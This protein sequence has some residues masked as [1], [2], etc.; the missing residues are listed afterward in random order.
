MIAPVQAPVPGADQEDGDFLKDVNPNSLTVI[1][2]AALEPYVAELPPGSR[3]QFERT[4]YF[5]VDKDS[6][7]GEVS[8]NRI[9]TLRD[10]W[11]AK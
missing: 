5:S 11:G 7:P 3:V 10:T 9:V 4:G 1:E 6:A 2:N 8:M